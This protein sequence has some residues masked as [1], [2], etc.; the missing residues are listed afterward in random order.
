MRFCSASNG[1]SKC[2]QKWQ[3]NGQQWNAQQAKQSE[4]K[5]SCMNK[6]L[7]IVFMLRSLRGTKHCWRKNGWRTFSNVKSRPRTDP[8]RRCSLGPRMLRSHQNLRVQDQRPCRKRRGASP[9]LRRSHTLNLSPVFP[10]LVFPPSALVLLQEELLGEGREGW[11]RVDL[12]LVGRVMLLH[13]WKPPRH[14]HE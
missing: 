14:E 9:S 11:D 8:R 6:V 10:T 12:R 5:P 3:Q 2:Q 4:D 1:C 7:V 13:L